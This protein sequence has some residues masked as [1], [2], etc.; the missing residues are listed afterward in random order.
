MTEG[1][2]ALAALGGAVLLAGGCFIAGRYTAP[3]ETKTEVEYVERLQVIRTTVVKRVV[4]TKTKTVIVERPDGTKTTVIDQEKHEAEDSKSSQVATN[5]TSA[6]ESHTVT[7]ARPNWRVGALVGVHLS[8]GVPAPVY[9]AVVE[10]RL[11]GPI[12]VGAWGLGSPTAGVSGG[13]ALSLEF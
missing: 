10:R 12:S 11:L 13:L 3:V 9:G 2:Y 5:D 4:D 8:P 7:S 1:R 6:K